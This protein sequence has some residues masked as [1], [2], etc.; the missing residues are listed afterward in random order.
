MEDKELLQAISQ[1]MDNK[2]APINKKINKMESK[3]DSLDNKVNE[4]AEELH[5]VR[6][7]QNV[8]AEWVESLQNDVKNLNDLHSA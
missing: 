1:I 5:E 2:L 7:A 8:I 6:G 3:I 4:M